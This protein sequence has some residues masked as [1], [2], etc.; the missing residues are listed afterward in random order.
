[1]ECVVLTGFVLE[2]FPCDNGCCGVCSG[3]RDTNHF[4]QQLMYCFSFQIPTKL[5]EAL[6]IAKEC[7]EKR[8]VEE[9]KQV[10]WLQS[11]TISVPVPCHESHSDWL[12][13]IHFNTLCI[14]ALNQN[15]SQSSP[16]SVRNSTCTGVMNLHDWVLLGGVVG[17]THFS[18][19]R[20]GRKEWEGEKDY[21]H[22][23]YPARID[24][25]LNHKTAG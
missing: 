21:H 22:L 14:V 16:Q 25:D 18:V 17:S 3:V 15:I 24:L 12:L 20:D 1:M 2:D 11:F 6:R 5:K 23:A 10:S 19:E 9:Q 13:T 7:I 4:N 8:L